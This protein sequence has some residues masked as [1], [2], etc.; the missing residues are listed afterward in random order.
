MNLILIL[1]VDLEQN[2]SHK[3]VSLAIFFFCIATKLNLVFNHILHLKLSK[4]N[5]ISSLSVDL[6]QNSSY[7]NVSQE[8]FFCIATK[9]NLV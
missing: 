8:I 1:Q 9:L 6:E 2:G 4:M 7:K 5:L 3:N